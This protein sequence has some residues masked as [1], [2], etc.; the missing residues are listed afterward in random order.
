MASRQ[1]ELQKAEFARHTQEMQHQAAVAQ[2]KLRGVLAH[3][4][5]LERENSQLRCSITFAPAVDADVLEA[6][7]QAEREAEAFRRDETARLLAEEDAQ[8]QAQEVAAAS[9]CVAT[10]IITSDLKTKKAS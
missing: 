7:A 2:A 8:R 3:V 1:Q 6:M 10:V 5:A 9:T 4:A